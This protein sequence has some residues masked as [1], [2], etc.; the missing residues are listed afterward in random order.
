VTTRAARVAAL[1]PG[2]DFDVLAIGGSAGAFAGLRSILPSLHHPQLV[3]IVLVHQAPH[4]G[5]LAELFQGFAGLPCVTVEDKMPAAPGAIYFAPAG[6]HLLTERT[7]HFA[8]SVDAPVNY[9]RPS[10]DV[11]FESV[12]EAYGARAAALVLTGANDD[13]AQGLRTIGNRGGITLVQDPRDAEVSMMPSSAIRAI[14]PHAVLTLKQLAELF[15]TW[16]RTVER[17]A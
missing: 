1:Q 10:I 7:G 15:A 5:D 17:R 2:V 4:G 14:E 16:S 9:S 6:Y 13:G 11:L 8:L 3:V 12:A